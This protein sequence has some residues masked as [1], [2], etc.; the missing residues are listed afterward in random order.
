MCLDMLLEILR[1]LECLSTE[2]A[3]MGLQRDM[4]TDVRGD[5][6]AFDC[7]GTAATPLAGQIEVICAFST[8]VTLANVFLNSNGQFVVGKEQERYNGG[9]HSRQS[10]VLIGE[11]NTRKKV[12]KGCKLT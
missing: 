1:T 5:V 8:D 7:C 6:I 10:R 9:W 3:L 4:D 12:A 2:L 11:Y